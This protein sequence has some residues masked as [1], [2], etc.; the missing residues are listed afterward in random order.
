MNRLEHVSHQ[1]ILASY[2]YDDRFMFMWPAIRLTICPN[3]RTRLLAFTRELLSVLIEE[4]GEAIRIIPAHVHS[5]QLILHSLAHTLSVSDPWDGIKVSLQPRSFGKNGKVYP[6]VAY[7]PFRKV[8][9]LLEHQV[10]DPFCTVTLGYRGFDQNHRTVIRPTCR[11]AD[12]M[13]TKS[14]L[15]ANH[16]Y[17]VA[18]EPPRAVLTV[19]VHP[20]KK[21]KD[22]QPL[23]RPLS[24]LEAVIPRLNDLLVRTNLQVAWPSFE[25][26]RHSFDPQTGY[27]RAHPNR[28]QL[29]RS[30]RYE[31]GVG[32][33]LEG[34]WVMNAPKDVRK[35]VTFDGIPTVELDFK[36]FHPVLAYHV[37]GLP[38]PG[39]DMYEI[40][41]WEPTQE[42]RTKFK[43]I[44]NFCANGRK[45]RVSGA[46]LMRS[47]RDRAEK[48]KEPISYIPSEAQTML[49]AFWKHHEPLR[50]FIGSEAW[51]TLQMA[52]SDIM[53]SI[54]NQLV[55]QGIP[56]IPI[57]D[58]AR[59][60][61]HHTNAL[62]TAMRKATEHMRSPPEISGMETAYSKYH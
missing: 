19:N 53:L 49:D 27:C 4:G 52:E 1:P 9:E 25:A 44:W 45:A 39:K 56:A 54:L 28:T 21:G 17:P 36:S 12:L 60:A 59:V 42:N 55:D 26:Y 7:Q 5:L 37:V 18:I 46:D 50:G 33:R 3:Y 20:D 38:M 2:R 40:P 24:E 8:A 16:P 51:K 35:L 14:L 10:D 43:H 23:N 15:W 47:G 11:L 6:G 22:Y 58:S 30:F 41:G 62:Y 13:T 29:Y 48:G 57:H 34:H 32:G 61:E 31:D